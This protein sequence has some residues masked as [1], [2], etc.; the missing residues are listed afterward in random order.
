MAIDLEKMREKYNKLK[1]GGS[2]GDN[3]LFWKPQEGTQMIRIVTPQNGD[4][5]RDLYFHYGLGEGSRSSALCPKRNYNE[6]C[7]VCEF[8]NGLWEDGDTESQNMAKDYF[9]KMRV[10]APVLV[11][12]EE[13]KGIRLWGFSKTAYENLLNIVLDP[14]YGDI[15]D[16][17]AGTDLRIDYGKKSGQAFPTTDIRPARKATP[18]MDSEEET[19]KLLEAMPNFEDAFERKSVDEVKTLLEQALGS[20][21]TA[22]TGSKETTHYGKTATKPADSKVSDIDDAFNELLA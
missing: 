14:E 2:G 6:K 8:A 9:A 11:R 5:F 3:D 7:P 16:T 10:F 20:D 21:A 4:P 22:E 17:E 15:T 12:G 18:L 19:M 13:D 1:G